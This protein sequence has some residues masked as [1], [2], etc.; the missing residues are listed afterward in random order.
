MFFAGR[1]NFHQPVMSG[2]LRANNRMLKVG[3]RGKRR[4]LE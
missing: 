3:L 4:A 1:V 2:F